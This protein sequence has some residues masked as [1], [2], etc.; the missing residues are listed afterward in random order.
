MT[1]PQKAALRVLRHFVVIEELPSG[2]VIV[3]GAGGRYALSRGGLLS[4]V[5]P[6]HKEKEPSALSSS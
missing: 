5:L 4:A 3:Q 1:E 2:V 6:P